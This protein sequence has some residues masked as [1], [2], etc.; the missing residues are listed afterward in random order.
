MTTL[1]VKFLKVPKIPEARGNL[2]FFQNLDQIPFE[3]KRVYWI[4]AIRGEEYENGHANKETNELIIALS[5][6]FEVMVFDGNEERLFKLNRPDICLSIPNMI[7]RKLFNF[8][9]NSVALIV[10][11]QVYSEDDRIMDFFEFKKGIQYA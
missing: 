2:S 10:A 8:S 6:S 3:M 11:D 5:G 7:W 9:T 1:D 4:N